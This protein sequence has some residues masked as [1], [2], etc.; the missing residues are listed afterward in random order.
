MANKRLKILIVTEALP[1]PLT[2][3]GKIC[4]YNFV[5][6]LRKLHDF[7]I[8]SPSYSNETTKQK[9]LLNSLWPEVKLECVDI[10]VPESKKSLLSFLAK[11]LRFV[12]GK[13]TGKENLLESIDYKLDFTD[14]FKP[15]SIKYISALKIISHSQPFDIIQIQFTRNLNL[16]STL[17]S[18]PKKIFEQI[19]SQYD[20][21]KDYAKTK[22]IDEN[23]TN[24]VV[25]NSEFLENAYINAYDAVFTLNEKDSTYFKSVLSKPSV[26]TTPFGVLDKDIPKVAPTTFDAKKIVFSG[27]ES[28][29]PNLDAL[30]WYIKE[31][32]PKV[33]QQLQLT[34]HITGTWSNET[35]ERFTKLCPHIKFEGFIDDYQ[36]FL[37][38]SIMIVPIR[39]GGGGLRTKILYAM[40]NHVP[41]VST[42]IGAFGIEGSHL[43]HYHISDSE[44]A[45][46]ES[47]VILATDQNASLELTKNASALVLEKYSQTKTSE[48][49]HKLYLEIIAK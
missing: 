38:D 9:Q 25:K 13:I 30:E 40:A 1:F 46:F 26:Y 5:D 32:Q 23:F 11:S 48:L 17:P 28:H 41:V 4:L 36:S 19:E 8:V 29:Y 42:T 24:H 37:K 6:H 34:L 2:S 47:I 16:L 18:Q 33:F 10:L 21:M 31:I 3:G 12:A 44:N 45:F 7:T 49:R 14:S 35:K 20:V 22:K 27:N 39:I 43:K 15:H